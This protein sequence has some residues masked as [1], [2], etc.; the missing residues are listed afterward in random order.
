MTKTEIY[1]HKQ[2]LPSS[3]SSIAN[4]YER[5]QGEEGTKT[6]INEEEYHTKVIRLLSFLSKTGD[7]PPFHAVN[8]HPIGGPIVAAQHRHVGPRR[9]IVRRPKPAKTPPSFSSSTNTPITPK[10]FKNKKEKLH[11]HDTIKRIS[12]NL[13]QYK[14]KKR[15]KKGMNY[16]SES[17]TEG[18]GRL[19][20]QALGTSCGR[21]VHLARPHITF[22]GPSSS[23]RRW[24]MESFWCSWSVNLAPFPWTWAREKM[25]KKWR[26]N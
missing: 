17:R 19:M 5:L 18:D 8:S 1:T 4:I 14:L 20:P 16:L 22:F 9:N 6:Y 21:S 11:Q 24:K 3:T 25:N 23:P 12:T 15:R 10:N 26:K 13:H 2:W 7:K